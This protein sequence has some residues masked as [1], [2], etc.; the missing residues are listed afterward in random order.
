[1]HLLTCM[2]RHHNRQQQA[3]IAFFQQG[4]HRHSECQ[5]NR[6][7]NNTGR[8]RSLPGR[9]LSGTKV[10]IKKGRAT[11]ALQN[12]CKKGGNF[13]AQSSSSL[14]T[15]PRSAAADSRPPNRR[16]GFHTAAVVSEK[17]ENMTI[18][19]ILK[20]MAHYCRFSRKNDSILSNG[21]TAEL[22]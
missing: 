3:G 12:T 14:S 19:N 9:N 11:A 10:I 16:P 17:E 7:G 18:K 20:F 4:T 13:P 21:M 5:G 6:A 15:Q 8:G 22:S 1:M 2:G